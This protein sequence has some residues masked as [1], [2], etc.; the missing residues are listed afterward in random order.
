MARGIRDPQS[1]QRIVQAAWQLVASV[2]LRSTT[3][4]AIA[5]EAGVTTG[6]VTHY[7]EDK[8]QIM[9]AVLEHNN[10]QAADRIHD[11]VRCRRG[12]AAVREHALALVPADAAGMAIWRVWLAFWMDRDV[13]DRDVPGLADRDLQHGWEEW[14]QHL[15]ALLRQAVSD[16][17]LPGDVDLWYECERIGTLVAGVGL[18]FGA[19][20]RSQKR[21]SARARKMLDEHLAAFAGP[22][23][24]GPAP[25]SRA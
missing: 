16:G 13:M 11:F 14:R 12:L 9:A 7:F 15:H 18:V 20:R 17:E 10:R 4:R 8:S 1:R 24:P 6:S 3:M 21:I 19:T 2:G 25:R 22:A 5:A 23:V